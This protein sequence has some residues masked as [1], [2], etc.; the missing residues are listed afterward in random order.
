MKIPPLQYLYRHVV[1]AYESECFTKIGKSCHFMQREILQ[2]FLKEKP[3][4]WTELEPSAVAMYLSSVVLN[5][6]AAFEMLCASWYYM[7]YIYI[8][9]LHICICPTFFLKFLHVNQYLPRLLCSLSS[10]LIVILLCIL[11]AFPSSRI[12]FSF[13][14]ALYLL[15]TFPIRNM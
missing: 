4:K 10:C 8:Y 12:S 13:S 14:Q 1:R 5:I 9:A 3:E 7:A 11:Q 15:L 6:L 2:S